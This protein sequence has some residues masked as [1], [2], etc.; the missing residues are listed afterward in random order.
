[1]SIESEKHNSI[2]KALLE[3]S[4]ITAKTTDIITRITNNSIQQLSSTGIPIP[5]SENID[6]LQKELI[7]LE[8]RHALIS[9]AIMMA[10][11]NTIVKFDNVEYRLIEIIEMIERNKKNIKR[12]KDLINHI[13]TNTMVAKGKSRYG[14]SEST[15]KF[16][17]TIDISVLRK[18][19]EKESH[20]KNRLQA[21]LQEANW[22]CPCVY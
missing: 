22:S 14:Y 6:D 19:I 17:S 9:N 10:N 1:M 5:S 15:D 20:L 3:R 4:A 16:I 2:G 21:L 12:L 7:I 13:E 11:Y 18:N 8:N